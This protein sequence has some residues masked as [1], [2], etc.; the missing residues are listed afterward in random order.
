[1]K[2]MVVVRIPN[3]YTR[4]FDF[5]TNRAAREFYNYVIRTDPGMEVAVTVPRK[6][7]A[8]KDKKK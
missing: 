5:P 4:I 7:R 2:Y 3:S 1:M 6:R 8:K